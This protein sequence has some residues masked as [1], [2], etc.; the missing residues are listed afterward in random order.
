MDATKLHRGMMTCRATTLFLV[1][2]LDGQLFVITCV[3][4]F[5]AIR[6]LLYCSSVLLRK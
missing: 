4:K 5:I 2:Y 6:Q 1:D 3:N